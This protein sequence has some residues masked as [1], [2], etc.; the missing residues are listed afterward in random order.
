M[1][2]RREG[3]EEDF[4][5]GTYVFENNKHTCSQYDVYGRVR[6]RK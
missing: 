3:K 2:R 5:D 6:L 1:E 4:Q